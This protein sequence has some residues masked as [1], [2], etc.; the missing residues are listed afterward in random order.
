MKYNRDPETKEEIFRDILNH[1]RSVFL[2]CMGY[3]KD[4]DDAEELAQDIYVKAWEKLDSLDQK[5]S[6]KGWLFMIT[7]N[8]CIDHVRKTKVR[9]LFI[10][11][12]DHSSHSLSDN[13]TPE[14]KVIFESKKAKLKVCV[15]SLPEKLRSVFILK[16]YSGNSCEEIAELLQIKLGTVHSR[17]TRGR[18][19]VTKLMEA[20]NG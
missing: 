11:A 2:I 15:S 4:I 14:E 12:K 6:A 13:N 5:R 18:E 20:F 10:A 1:R 7:R 9:N 19:K 8:R 3:T 17:L 16:E